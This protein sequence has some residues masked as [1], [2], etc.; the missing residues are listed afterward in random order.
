MRDVRVETFGMTDLGRV[1]ANNEDQFLIAQ[2]SKSLLIEQTSLEAQ[3]HTRLISRKQGH[4]FLVADGMGG[5]PAGERASALAVEFSLKYVLNVMP[6][7]YR[8]KDSEDD[9]T[10]ELEKALR[11]CQSRIEADA[12]ENPSRNG[13]GTTLTMAYVL[14]PRIYVVHVGDS[15]CYVFRNSRLEQVTHDHTVAQ[16]LEDKSAITARQGGRWRR[17]LWNV[18]GGGT[19]DLEPEV[20]RGELAESDTLLLAT[21]GLTHLISDKQIAQVLSEAPSA[22][23]A[24]RNLIALANQAGG[25]DNTSVV[26]A[27][28]HAPEGPEGEGIYATVS[29]EAGQPLTKTG[30]EISPEA[31]GEASAPVLSSG[32]PIC[33]QEISALRLSQFGC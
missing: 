30:V 3:D 22:E 26:V 18:V 2:L 6:W 17:V 29:R 8:L 31:P 4:L 12:Q 21:D 15:R 1:R 33:E 10:E 28:F 25:K 14:W 19:P 27:R 5:A 32:S 7:F 9:L 23:E 24:C 16:Q 13:M 11:Q 20:Y